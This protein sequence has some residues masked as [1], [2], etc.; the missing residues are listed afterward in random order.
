MTR[1]RGA[2]WRALGIFLGVV[3]LLGILVVLVSRGVDRRLATTAWPERI[4][5]VR[6]EPTRPVLAAE[7]IGSDNA[8]AFFQKMAD[9]PTE[10]YSPDVR[11]SLDAFA[12]GTLAEVRCPQLDAWPSERADYLAMMRAV[13]AAPSSQAPTAIGFDDVVPVSRYAIRDARMLSYL[14]S[15]AAL[16]GDWEQAW[17]WFTLGLDISRQ[18][19]PGGTL[20]HH[21]VAHAGAGIHLASLR[22]AASEQPPPAALARAMIEAL[23]AWPAEMEPF[24]EA[25]RFERLLALDAV[26]HVYRGAAPLVRQDESTASGRMGRWIAARGPTSL[27]ALGSTPEQTRRNVDAV[28]SHLIDAAESGRLADTEASLFARVLPSGNRARIWYMLNDPV[29]RMLMALMLPATGRAEHRVRT[30]FV[31]AEATAVLLALD[32]YRGDHGHYPAA[33]AALAP[34]YLPRVPED[35][36]A[37]GQ[38]LCYAHDGD[39][40]RLYS[41]GPNG[42]DHGGERDYWAAETDAERA[43]ADLVFHP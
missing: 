7:D 34:D 9:Y 24:A 6:L 16:D 38:P 28:Y 42:R 23:L 25:I 19:P 31:H 18:Q 43:E 3:A 27:H 10:V 13:A 32:L 5:G 14:G 41:V 35:R 40:F 21:L 12:R 11:E 30:T 33:L 39:A 20:I 29:G 36:F 1:S 22:K 17:D 15:G 2:G 4:E 26:D 8:Y 37:P